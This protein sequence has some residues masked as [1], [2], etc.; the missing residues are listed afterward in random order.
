MV[1]CR[2]ACVLLALLASACSPSNEASPRLTPTSPTPPT[3]APPVSGVRLQMSGRV[4][5]QNGAPV[6]GA[7]VE[8]DYPAAGAVS[9]PPSH[10]PLSPQ[11][12]WLSTRTN[13]LVVHGPRGLVGPDKPMRNRRHRVGRGHTECP[14]APDGWRDHAVSVLVYDGQLRRSHHAVRTR[15]RGDSGARQRLGPCLRLRGQ[16]AIILSGP[17]TKRSELRKSERSAVS[18][19]GCRRPRRNKW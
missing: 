18:E 2:A 10:C 3:P 19:P 7:V 15:N 1:K 17:R 13:D 8:V 5:D 9:N 6:S 12:C 11:Y 16:T 14:G 4:L